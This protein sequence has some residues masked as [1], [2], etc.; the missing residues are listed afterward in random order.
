M[1]ATRA[2]FDANQTEDR[3]TYTEYPTDE[4]QYN[5]NCGICNQSLY[6]DK[7]QYESVVRAIEEGLDNP[8]VCDD[9]REEYAE[10]EHQGH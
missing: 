6:V 4:N 10:L 8:F 3:G 9:C 2:Q 7:Q 1:Q 5:V